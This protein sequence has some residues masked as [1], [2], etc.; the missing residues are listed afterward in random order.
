MRTTKLPKMFMRCANRFGRVP[1][2]NLF[3]GGEEVLKETQNTQPC[4]F[5]LELSGA[6]MLLEKGVCP[7]GL[8]GFS[9]G[10]VVA[11]TVS[12]MFSEEEG[13]R[14]ICQRGKWMQEAAKEVEATMVV[15]LKL[16]E[17]QV[18]ELCQR[19]QQVYP[20]NFN[21]PGQIVVSGRK[22]EMDAFR[23]S[24]KEAGGRTLPLKV[25]G[26]F[27][28]PFMKEASLRLKEDLEKVERRSRKYPLY[29]NVTGGLYGTQEVELLSAQVCQPVLWEKV[30]RTMIEDGVDCFIEIG[31]GKTLTNMLG[32]IDESVRGFTVEEYLK[33][34]E[35]RG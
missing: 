10:E 8:A 27:H 34:I 17:H 4:L 15:V 31:P 11:A 30:I 18:R 13:F 35:E 6:K 19:Y 9:L 28:S 16:E 32:K 1:R 21:C 5:A 3:F 14:L 25:G 29:S 33:E 7:D 22:E 26:G 2:N 20:V 24:V 12:G 23:A